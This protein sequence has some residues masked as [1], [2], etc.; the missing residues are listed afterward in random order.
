MTEAISFNIHLDIPY[1]EAIEKLAEELK[2]DGFGILTRIDV[3]ATMKEKLGAD[4]RKYAILG[5]CNPPL[6]HRALSHHTEVGLMLPCNVIV[7]ED[8]QDGGS[9][10]R[11]GD[12]EAFMRAGG[13][14]TDPVLS[15]VGAE[16]RESLKRVAGRLEAIGVEA[17]GGAAGK[18]SGS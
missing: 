3:K 15:A 13:F 12:P 14:D 1:E 5:V 10:I 7:E 16:A 17:S 9:I 18:G 2:E 6:A 8:E 4:F 11:I